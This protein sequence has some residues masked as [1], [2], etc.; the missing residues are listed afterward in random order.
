LDSLG[1]YSLVKFVSLVDA[2][3]FAVA[4]QKEI[5]ARNSEL[6]DNHRMKFCVVIKQS[7]HAEN[8]HYLSVKPYDVET[9]LES[10]KK[11]K[12]VVTA[13]NQSVIRGP[14]GAVYEVLA[15]H[16][17]VRVKRLGAQD[18]FD[19]VG[20]VAYLTETLGFSV[21]DIAMA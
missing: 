6:P 13:E 20:D 15:E 5:N 7:A 12:A 21:Q 2:V 10:V 14:G 3:Q 17:P 8:I 16:Y 11:T 18:R 19:E 9:L 1:D 4:V